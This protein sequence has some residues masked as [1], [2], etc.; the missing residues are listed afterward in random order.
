MDP[1]GIVRNRDRPRRCARADAYPGECFDRPHFRRPLAGLNGGGSGCG[2]RGSRL[3]DPRKAR[4]ARR[5]NV[6]PSKVKV[7]RKY[8]PDTRARVIDETER[9]F[10][11][12][13]ETIN[14]SND[15]P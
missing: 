14:H 8:A 7:W 2:V 9:P 11:T 15:F 5:S 4:D 6:C 13:S 12:E 3:L 10:Y 1:D